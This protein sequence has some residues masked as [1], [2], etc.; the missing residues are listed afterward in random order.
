MSSIAEIKY[1][2]E[3]SEIT[4]EL[5][6]KTIHML[7]ALVPPL[8]ALNLQMTVMMLAGGV[9]FY[10]WA[11]VQR[12]HGKRVAVVSMLTTS[13]SRVRDRDKLVLGPVTLGVGA[14]LALLLYPQPAAAMAIYALAFGDGLASLVGKVFGK[15]ELPYTGGKTIAGSLTCFISVLMV[16]AGILPSYGAAMTVAFSATV[17]EMFP[18][19]DMDNIILPTGVGLITM[20]LM[21]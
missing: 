7:I 21:L 3:K 17:L 20:L 8:A 2:V 10:T 5:I 9:L 12:L 4:T 14:M 1:F 15:I 16:A 18:T 13:A 11:E 19:R 6:R